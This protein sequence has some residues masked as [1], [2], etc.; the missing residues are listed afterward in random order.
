MAIRCVDFGQR[1][2]CVKGIINWMLRLVLLLPILTYDI[3]FY[4]SHVMLHSRFLYAYHSIHHSS[5][6]NKLQ[7]TDTY[8]GHWFEGPF[9][10]RRN[11][12]ELCSQGAG[13]FFPY[14]FFQYSWVDTFLVLAFLNVRAKVPKALAAVRM[15][16]RK[17]SFTPSHE[18]W[19]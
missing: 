9:Q 8:V 5:N 17:S 7:L 10:L 15:V 6:P 1:K 19:I 4:I 2:V 11:S 12:W 16:N 14:L 18:S 13:M 3:W